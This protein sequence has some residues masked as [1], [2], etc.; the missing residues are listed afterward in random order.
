MTSIILAEYYRS[1]NEPQF[2]E[3]TGTYLY[4]MIVLMVYGVV[5]AAES[6]V[7][8]RQTTHDKSKKWACYISLHLLRLILIVASVVLM[9]FADGNEVLFG[10][11][12]LTNFCV[13]VI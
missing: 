10:L 8:F 13:F 7:L 2:G 12:I 4:S 3:A 9:W 5:T 11:W 1:E 6:F